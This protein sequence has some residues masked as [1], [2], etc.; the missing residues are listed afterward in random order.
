MGQA[1]SLLFLSLA[2]GLTLA[3]VGCAAT[4]SATLGATPSATSSSARVSGRSNPR[5]V[6]QARVLALGA[7][8]VEGRALSCAVTDATVE[9]T[10]FSLSA[11]LVGNDAAT[12]TVAAVCL[13]GLRLGAGTCQGNVIAREIYW[14]GLLTIACRAQ[15]S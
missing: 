7:C 6:C 3:L 5:L 10:S 13:G 14:G 11:T 9:E 12:Q 2:L 1:R 8:C 4:S 15:P